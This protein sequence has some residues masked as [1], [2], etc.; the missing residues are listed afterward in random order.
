[1]IRLVIVDDHPAVR[2]SYTAYLREVADFDVVG[3]AKNGRE[4]VDLCRSDG[5]DVVLMDVQMPVMDGIEATRLI[6]A[7]RPETKVILISAYEQ[8]ELIDAG[9]RAGAD[10]FVIKGFSGAELATYVKGVAA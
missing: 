10:R 9:L 5:P 8:P 7:E 2:L 1:V 4:A 6:K 3:E